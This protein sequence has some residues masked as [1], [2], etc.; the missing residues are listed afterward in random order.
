MPAGDKLLNA[1]G[2]NW[3]F[4]DRFRVF[5]GVQAHDRYWCLPKDSPSDVANPPPTKRRQ[6]DVL[7]NST[8][9]RSAASVS[10]S[11]ARVERA[12]AAGQSKCAVLSL[13]QK[14]GFKRYSLFFSPRPEDQA[15]YPAPKCMRDGGPELLPYD[16]MPMFLRKAVPRLWELFAG[17]IDTH[18]DDQPCV[19]P[20]SVRDAVGQ[21]IEDGPPTIPLSQARQ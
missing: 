1:V 6:F 14:D 5:G 8:P 18:G 20:K 7:G 16:S 10:A 9:R 2:K 15:R 3:E 21:E 13:A 17:K 19:I 4:S 11:A 12:R